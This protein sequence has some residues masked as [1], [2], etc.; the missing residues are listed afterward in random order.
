M[1]TLYHII[2]YVHTLMFV[3]PNV[4][5]LLISRYKQ[6]KK[7]KTNFL[8]YGLLILLNLECIN[9]NF[10]IPGLPLIQT[11]LTGYEKRDHSGLF[12]KIKFLAWI[13][14]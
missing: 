5:K 11:I 8:R 14:S 9:V 13:D 2:V 3:I 12:I 6:L 7:N 4:G 1:L 10:I